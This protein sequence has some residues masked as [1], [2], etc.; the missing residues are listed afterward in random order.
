M[1]DDE[2]RRVLR[3]HRG[4]AH[5]ARI[6]GQRGADRRV[7]LEASDD[8]HDLHQRHGVEEV[9]PGHALRAFQFGRDRG[10]GQGGGVAGQHGVGAHNAL[11]FRKQGRFHIQALDD[12]LHHQV[13][14]REVLQAGGSLESPLAGRR[15]GSVHAALGREL[16]P[17][18]CDGLLRGRHGGGLLVV[19]GDGAAG[20]GGDLGNAAAHGAGADDGDVCVDGF[21]ARII[22]CGPQA[23]VACRTVMDAGVCQTGIAASPMP[24]G[25]HQPRIFEETP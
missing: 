19:E 14:A 21:H 5:L 3:S 20:L 11:E 1:V 4:V 17:L 9:V 10:D 13:A 16:V 22:T 15:G 2:A 7:G 23:G 8:L 25:D 24:A 6:F 18:V 12:G